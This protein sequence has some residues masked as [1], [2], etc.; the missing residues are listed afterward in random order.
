MAGWHPE[1][2]IPRGKVLTL[3][4]MWDQPSAAEVNRGSLL[5]RGGEGPPLG[6]LAPL[7]MAYCDPG[8]QPLPPNL[9]SASGSCAA[10]A[11]PT[12]E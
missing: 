9:P 1:S 11:D 5:G 4:L 6:S 10:P 12:S 3:F 8:P 2:H 7:P